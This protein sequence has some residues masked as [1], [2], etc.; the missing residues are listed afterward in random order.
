M[1]YLY[2]IAYQYIYI[3]CN[4]LSIFFFSHSFCWLTPD[5]GGELQA[6]F[7]SLKYFGKSYYPL[8][9]FKIYYRSL[10]QRW[11]LRVNAWVIKYHAALVFPKYWLDIMV[12]GAP[13]FSSLLIHLKPIFSVT[14][15]HF[16]H[17]TASELPGREQN[18]LPLLFKSI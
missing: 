5:F 8:L 6:I 13:A 2:Y 3:P 4:F 18:D 1:Q 16:S 17:L 9:F 10:Q 7:V 15:L 14:R 11:K 12:E